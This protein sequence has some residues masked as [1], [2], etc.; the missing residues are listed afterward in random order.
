MVA[1]KTVELEQLELVEVPSDTS[2]WAGV[3]VGVLIG[4]GIVAFT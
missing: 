2:Y 4:A 1:I 3:G